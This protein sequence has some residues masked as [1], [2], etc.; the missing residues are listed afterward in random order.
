LDN[1]AESVR[2]HVSHTANVE[3]VGFEPCLVQII[4]THF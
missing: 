2:S 3:V 4:F 1:I